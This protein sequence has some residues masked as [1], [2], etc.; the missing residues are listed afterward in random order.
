MPLL[1]C[2]RREDIP[3]LGIASLIHVQ[4]ADT[5]RQDFGAT[6]TTSHTASTMSTT[7]LSSPSFSS[8]RSFTAF[9]SQTSLVSP[10]VEDTVILQHSDRCMRNRWLRCVQGTQEPR[11]CRDLGCPMACERALGR[12]ARDG[13][14]NQE[15]RIRRDCHDHL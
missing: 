13:G 9:S 4:V 5:S 3:A 8:R 10:R 2:V 15:H 7:G 6:P 11:S 12:C 14:G 1:K